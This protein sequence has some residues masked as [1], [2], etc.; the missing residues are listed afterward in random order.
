MEITC[1]PAKHAE[2]LAERGLDFYDAA[3]VFAGDTITQ[4]DVRIA[5]PELRYQTIG[6][7]RGRMVFVVW[8]PNG[9]ACHVISMRKCNAREQKK[10]GK[11]FEEG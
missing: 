10:F 2:T 4:E 9:T 5:Y 3:L 7:L 8:T 6:F 11:R 1:N